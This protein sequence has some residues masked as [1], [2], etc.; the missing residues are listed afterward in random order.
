MKRRRNLWALSKQQNPI[1]NTRLEKTDVER[2]ALIKKQKQERQRLLE[3]Q[4]KKQAQETQTRQERYRQG[5]LGFWDQFTGRRNAIKKWDQQ[6]TQNFLKRD[7]RERNQLVFK[8]LWQR[9]SLKHRAERLEEFR[10]S[11]LALNKNDIEQF[12]EICQRQRD[13]F[14]TDLSQA[15]NPSKR[16]TSLER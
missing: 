9:N 3:A 7:Q 5:L 8:N 15:Y 16:S 4:A 1:I 14:D 2:R 11:S 13:T 6:E 12:N 10:Y